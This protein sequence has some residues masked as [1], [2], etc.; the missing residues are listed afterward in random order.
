MLRERDVPVVSCAS[1]RSRCAAGRDAGAAAAANLAG[2]AREIRRLV[3][4]LEP[5]LVFTWGMRS[6]LGRSG[7]P[8]AAATGRRGSRATTTSCRDPPI[9][10]ALRRALRQ[11]D[12]VVVNSHAVARRPRLGGPSR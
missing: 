7:R 12:A 2:H 8:P 11:A 3:R 6:A 10:A 1:G 5:P 4:E 9:G